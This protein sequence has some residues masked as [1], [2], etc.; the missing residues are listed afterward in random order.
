MYA[1]K[2]VR[3][4]VYNKT[5]KSYVFSIIWIE[6]GLRIHDLKITDVYRREKITP[7]ETIK[8]SRGAIIDTLILDNISSENETEA[9]EIPMLIN[10]GDVKQ[11]YIGNIRVD[12]QRIDLG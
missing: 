6:G 10:E 2:A 9:K 12:G 3:K 1:S 8:I 4:A 5:E 11:L 7:V